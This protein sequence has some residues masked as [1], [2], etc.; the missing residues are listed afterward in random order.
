MCPRNPIKHAAAIFT[1]VLALAMCANAM[2]ATKEQQKLLD[3][4]SREGFMAMRDI[5]LAR[6]AIFSGHANAATPLVENAKQDLATAG[7]EAGNAT[8]TLKVKEQPGAKG[9]KQKLAEIGDLISI[10]A[11]VALTEDFTVTPEKRKTVAKANAHLK[12]GEVEKAVEALKAADIGVSVVHTLIPVKATQEHVDKAIDLLK[13]HKYYE[14]NLA[15]KAAEDGEIVDA[16]I[17]YEPAKGTAAT[18]K[19]TEPEKKSE[20]ESHAE[21]ATNTHSA[22]K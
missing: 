17:A 19:A 18:K 12:K 7:K 4:A 14:A 22:H 2:A 10:D 6:V 1:A 9:E 21:Q 20:S 5:G 13:D 8:V 3:K 11:A 16:I 15:L